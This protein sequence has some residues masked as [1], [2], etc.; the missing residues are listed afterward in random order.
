VL[1]GR[2]S[3]YRSTTQGQPA[4]AR[5][6]RL[7]RR[8]RGGQDVS[9]LGGRRGVLDRSDE[10]RGWVLVGALAVTETISYGVLA[11]AFSVFVVPLQRDLGWSLAALTGAYTVSTVVSGAAAVP[12]GRWLDRHGPRALMTT[13]SVLG[14][15][16]VLAWAAVDQ[17]WELYAIWTGIGLVI[18]M[19]CYE[20]AFAT[21]TAWF[22]SQR[23]RALLVLTV[24]AGFASTIFVPLTGWLVQAHGW[25]HALVVLAVVLAVGTIPPHAL[26]LRRP[27]APLHGPPR[28]ERDVPVPT[29]K[30]GGM[31]WRVAVHTGSFRWLAVAFCAA[32]LST[33]TIS[34]HLV[35]ALHEA[36]HPTRTAATWAGLLG[37]MSVTGRLS[38]TA[39]GRR[40]PLA[41]VTGGMFALQA[42][43]AVVLLA[44]HNR[45]AL[46]LFVALFG[47]G[48]GLISLSRAT[49]VADYY[50]V[51]HYASINGLLAALLTGAR[52]TAPTLAGVLRASS[53]SYRP[54]LVAVA[55]AS[56][57]AA[58]G[59]FAAHT[60]ARTGQ[61][62]DP[63]AAEA[64][65]RSRA[66]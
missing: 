42:A 44:W 1:P 65:H 27:R 23:F 21:I 63:V 64:P 4:G 46:P 48:F 32:T 51:E 7:E 41:I 58:A 20:P 19:V 10:Q 40:L 39:I 55:V 8:H 66:A 15:L 28:P 60:A 26:L 11:Y 30:A 12:V 34:V 37:A 29:R 49:L 53:G 5:P 56:G 35:A 13:G 57:V 62:A 52:A 9:S 2:P 16:L 61:R 6:T 17:L 18:A 50:G 24:V 38:T 3:A 47:I 33:T 14:T 25:R 22:G 36:G 54:V 43:G 59:M 31:P 45:A